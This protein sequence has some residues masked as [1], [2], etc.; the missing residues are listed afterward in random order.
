[1]STHAVVLIE[2]SAN[3]WPADV[4]ALRD[5]GVLVLGCD[6]AARIVVRS[7]G[8]GPERVA[9]HALATLQTMGNNDQARKVL[10]DIAARVIDDANQEL[11]RREKQG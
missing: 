4:Q 7:L 1:M 3:A 2:R 10:A 11:L 9:V 6:D 5:A 8:G